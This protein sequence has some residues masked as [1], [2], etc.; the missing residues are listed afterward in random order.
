MDFPIRPHSGG[1]CDPRTL[2]SKVTIIHQ[3]GVFQSPVK[4]I[5]PP[6]EQKGLVNATMIPITQLK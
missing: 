1:L 3:I 4:A 2:F 5:I 6:N